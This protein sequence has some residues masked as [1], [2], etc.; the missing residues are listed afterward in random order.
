M[1]DY[2]KLAEEKAKQPVTI[3]TSEGSASR[4][5]KLKNDAKYFVGKYGKAEYNRALNYYT[6]KTYAEQYGIDTKTIA[7]TFSQY[8]DLV[9]NKDQ[10]KQ[11]YGDKE[12]KRIRDYYAGLSKDD[13]SKINKA[14]SYKTDAKNFGSDLFEYSPILAERYKYD[15]ADAED[16]LRK[17]IGVMPKSFTTNEA[18][19]IVRAAKEIEK[20]KNI[21]D[22]DYMENAVSTG[23]DSLDV[24]DS[25]ITREDLI[26]AINILNET[27][28]VQGQ[29]QI[30]QAER[31]AQ[32]KAAVT[33][34]MNR[35]SAASIPTIPQGKPTTPTATTR[36]AEQNDYSNYSIKELDSEAS[37]LEATIS[38]LEKE[39]KK[40]ATAF[41]AQYGTAFE[42]PEKTSAYES[43]SNLENRIQTM[44]ETLASIKD[45][46]I[47]KKQTDY[48]NKIA[49]K[50]SDYF[51][52]SDFEE[53]VAKGAALENAASWEHGG[54]A[55]LL[56]T[57][58]PVKNEVK[59]YLDNTKTGGSEAYEFL[60]NDEKNLYNYLVAKDE[61]QGTALANQ[62][63]KD[64]KKILSGRKMSALIKTS[65]ED[66]E[67]FPVLSSIGSVL[68]SPAKGA[69]YLY[70]AAQGL[71]GSEVD[72][73]N[74]A[75]G[76]ARAQQSVRGTISKNIEGDNPDFLKSAASFLYG[77]GMSIG[78]FLVT[79]GFA[80]GASKAG[81]AAVL[82]IMGTSSAT[83]ATL[84]AFDRGATQDQAL[85]AGFWTGIA[86]VFFE[87]FSLDNFIKLGSQ[88][89]KGAFIKSILKQSG[90]EASEEIATEISNTISDNI[91]MGNLSNYNLAVKQY[92]SNGMTEEAAK[93]RATWDVMG[94]IGLA[95]LGGLLSGMVTGSGATFIGGINSDANTQT[96]AKQTTTQTQESMPSTQTNAQLAPE[97]TFY[98]NQYGVTADTQFEQKALP[99]PKQ[100]ELPETQEALTTSTRTKYN[101][102]KYL[103]IGEDYEKAKPTYDYYKNKAQKD[104]KG[105]DVVNR[106]KEIVSPNKAGKRT[107]AQW[108]DVAEFI[109]SNIDSKM[110]PS[111]V[112]ELAYRSW[113]ENRPN[114]KDF[115][116][117]QGEKYVEFTFDEWVN[118]IYDNAI[119]KNPRLADRNVLYIENS[120]GVKVPFDILMKELQDASGAI[121]TEQ[122][123]AELFYYYYKQQNPK[124]IP[125]E[126]RGIKN[127]LNRSADSKNNGYPQFDNGRTGRRSGAIDYARAKGERL[128]P[129]TI[130]PS[131]AKAIQKSTSTIPP[132]PGLR[133]VSA[134]IKTQ[135]AEIAT[136][137]TEAQQPLSSVIDKTNIEIDNLNQ[138]TLNDKIGNTKLKETVK[139]ALGMKTPLD[140]K[141]ISALSEMESTYQKT[142][143]VTQKRVAKEFV[144]SNFEHA[145]RYI[146]ENNTLQSNADAAIASEIIDRY[147]QSGRADEA[148]EMIRQ[149]AV[150]F[151]KAGQQVQSAALWSKMT[152]E[153]TVKA[154][155]SAISKFNKKLGKNNQFT[156]SAES[157]KFLMDTADKIN[158]LDAQ[159]LADL[160]I[161]LCQKRNRK[162]GKTVNTKLD[163]LVKQN[164][165]DL[166]KDI[167][168]QS[169]TLGVYDEIPRTLG[170]KASTIQAFS[171]LLNPRTI[172]RNITSNTVFKYQEVLT[173]YPAAFF[174][175]LMSLGTKQRTVAAPSLKI[176]DIKRGHKASVDYAADANFEIQTGVRLNNELS[177]YELFKGE[178]FTATNSK[179]LHKVEKMLGYA[180]RTPDQY[181]KGAVEVNEVY[182]QLK[183]QG[184]DVE[185]K[186]I[187]QLLGM[188]DNETLSIA[189]EQALYNTFQNDGF[190]PGLLQ[191][192]KKTLNI[193]GIN[194]GD[195][196]LGDLT[197]KYTKVPGNLIQRSIDYTPVGALKVLKYLGTKNL[198]RTQQRDIAKTLGRALVS[199]TTLIGVSYVLSKLGIIVSPPDNDDK[200]RKFFEGT[201]LSGRKINASAIE[202]VLKG[203]SAELKDGDRLVSFDYLETINVPLALGHELAKAI[204]NDVP[205][206]K[207]AKNILNTFTD[208][209]LDLPTMYIINKM[210]YEGMKEDS[211]AIDVFAVPFLEAIPGFIP[212]PIRQASTSLDS[213]Q[214]DT[215][216]FTDRLLSNTPLRGELP[217]RLG[218]FGQPIQKDSG[219]LSFF[220]P[221][222]SSTYSPFRFSKELKRLA[223]AYSDY[224][225]YPSGKPTKSFSRDKITY[226]LT[227][228]EQQK[229]M[230]QYG[231]MLSDFY[232]LAL[233]AKISDEEKIKKL[234]DAQK[235]FREALKDNYVFN[236]NKSKGISNIPA[237]PKIK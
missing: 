172:L 168:Y 63:L 123:I 76:P 108:L 192:V 54:E 91:I 126:T 31:T 67:R 175:F 29:R 75:F 142:D 19:A 6:T 105:S 201:G 159:G 77:T 174:D 176:A 180:L 141:F 52:A 68:I 207:T 213:T 183:L 131:E 197:I 79:A 130:T 89:A 101:P 237:M 69:G 194:K 165:I 45:K 35:Y 81:E 33:D 74:A 111:E 208:E 193:A 64:M 47:E 88:S 55:E 100:A 235:Y 85:S 109:G 119:R 127:G 71:S 110:T 154:V 84:D 199:S 147:R 107:K 44:K 146:K 145:E 195:F 155:E 118:K 216:T 43:L 189:K 42:S 187:D 132:A 23:W 156:L 121:A 150:K 26:K 181:A 149:T 18:K 104:F 30:E 97:K 229:F 219:I 158:T 182:K 209:A 161:D 17:A 3:R 62:Y 223:E 113:F 90:I 56:N 198:T 8:D 1:V 49:S 117:R 222:T 115:L 27:S 103:F 4:L 124:R 120:Q 94:N 129:Y 218:T 151:S 40:E 205:V 73:N 210:V 128:A 163:A 106:A 140:E 152:P 226:A 51:D 234:K 96:T 220:N 46:N 48:E 57:S 25:S 177:K 24:S 60:S 202:R 102:P 188:A 58:K 12:Y 215:K 83:D 86:E 116:N 11:K 10:Y 38:Y 39:R 14:V 138:K 135:K 224:D 144:D 173:D 32:V 61:E 167:T 134:P 15:D 112:E 236:L 230:K 20:A 36:Q 139:N 169:M 170:Q 232:N 225:V 164:N 59:F 137:Q 160:F 178:T 171:H 5:E 186:T 153:G 87:K 179:F 228:E 191:S 78:D 148:L 233:S 157:G 190:I 143:N 2:V 7:P 217:E 16:Q 185:G 125:A 50:W 133:S 65:A 93:S 95:G 231:E 211:T 13:I 53:Y 72:P 203:E 80:G 92:T 41:D 9:T 28:G 99:A 98:S 196:G 214:R 136:A 70:A 34:S 212:S 200:E 206:E 204:D 227:E 22:A 37:S 114:R 82:A 21:T 221:G 184:K 66:A 122:D 162:I 166:L